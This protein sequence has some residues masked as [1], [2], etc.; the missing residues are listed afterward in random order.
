V[1]AKKR[2]TGLLVVAR[3]VRADW[4]LGVSDTLGLGAGPVEEGVV[5]LSPPRMVSVRMT[6][7]ATALD[8]MGLFDH[9]RPENPMGDNG[10]TELRPTWFV[11]RR[12]AG[13]L[14]P[15]SGFQRLVENTHSEESGPGSVENLTD[16]GVRAPRRLMERKAC[17]RAEVEQRRGANKST[18][19]DG[20]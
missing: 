1:S 4:L 16:A 9:K 13:G 5:E 19:G 12:P 7:P 2:G 3:D 10:Y 17:A 20:E 18:N 11:G 14:Y 15:P 8:R 6:E